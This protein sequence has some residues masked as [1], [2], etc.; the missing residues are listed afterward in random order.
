MPNTSD[1]SK[2]KAAA[3][4]FADALQSR[5]NAAMQWIITTTTVLFGDSC[6]RPAMDESLVEQSVLVGGRRCGRL[7][8]TS[9]SLT[10]AIRCL[11]EEKR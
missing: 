5:D 8:S 10:Q 9:E 2:L 6:A 3:V 11:V 4:A 7:L 1:D